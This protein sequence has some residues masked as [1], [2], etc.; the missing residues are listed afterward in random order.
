MDIKIVLNQVSVLFILLVTGVV[1]GK[2][3]LGGK[4]FGRNIASL[5]FHLALPAM[6]V[7]SM[8]YPFS[9]SMLTNGGRL[10]A[11][12]I[13]VMLISY[14]ASLIAL[15]FLRVDALSRNIYQ[16]GI[17]FSNFGF[18]GYP[19]IEALLGREGVFYASLFN[20]PIYL[21]INSYGIMLIARGEKSRINMK[22]K[23]ILNAPILA[24][25]LGFCMF[26]LSVKLPGTLAVSLSMIGAMTTPLSMI[27]I[28]FILSA[29]RLKQLFCSFKVYL[30]SLIRLVVLPMIVLIV[31][32]ALNLGSMITAVAVITTAMPVAVN[33]SI[34][35]EKY[36]GNSFLAAQLVFISTLLSAITI[37]IIILM[38]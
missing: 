22:L 1:I 20:L 9:L 23:N 32:K 33:A 31:L 26:L 4:D 11:I 10:I 29:A 27:L 24:V 7:S 2:L 38:L 16:Y 36:K 34:L 21:L 13:A 25:L 14:G 5:V 12:G 3:K 19:I 18:M 17:L 35:A 37:P 28:G 30:V 15:R 8:S 6:I